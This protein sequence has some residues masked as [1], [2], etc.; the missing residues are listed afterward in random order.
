[1]NSI[2]LLS[3]IIVGVLTFS[4]CKNN[5]ALTKRHYTKGYHFHKTKSID[6]PEVKEDIASTP[7]EKTKKASAMEIVQV[8]PTQTITPEIKNTIFNPVLTANASINGSQNVIT[9]KNTA[10]ETKSFDQAK[11][12]LQRGSK[13]TKKVKKDVDGNFIVMVI[14]ACFPILCLIAVYLHDKDITMN[15][16]IDLILH[17]TVIGAMVYALLLVFDVIDFA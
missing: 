4:S 7:S 10:T 16:W 11:K 17:I 15:F 14:L 5:M 12:E 8:K 1:M 9:K 6:Q 13:A 3:L 2:K